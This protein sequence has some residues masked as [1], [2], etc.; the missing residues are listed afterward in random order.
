MFNYIIDCMFKIRSPQISDFT[1]LEP[2][3]KEHSLF[4]EL[5]KNKFLYILQSFV[6]VNLRIAPSIHVAAD[7]KNILGFIVLKSSSKPNNCW[8]IEEVFVLDQVRNKGVGEEL[9]KYVLSLY[10]GEGIEHFLAEVDSNN[11]PALSL[12]QQCG[13]RRYAKVCF[14]EKEINIEILQV[15]SLL[16]KDF[17]LRTQTNSDL[18]ELEKLELSSV[19]PDL[20]SA[21]GRSKQYFKVRKNAVVVTNKSRNMVIGWANIEKRDSDNYFVE[22]LAG[23]GWT[24]LYEELLNTI[25]CDYLASKT[26]NIKLSVK[27]IDYNTELTQI[28]SKSGFLPSEIKELLVRTIWQKVKEKQ[29]KKAKFGAPSI[30]PT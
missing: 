28:L 14:Y 18:N 4:I 23:P 22:L 29:K 25:I 12:F 20:R 21:L 27:V 13:F 6:P 26:N 9:L 3:F 30:A 16:D 2:L 7:G 17:I 19:P 11:A 8:Q 10:G 1:K 24:H 15:S 5:N